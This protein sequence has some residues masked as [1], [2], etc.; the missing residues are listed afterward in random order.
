M[1]AGKTTLI[2]EFCHQLGSSDNFSSPTFTIVNEYFIPPQ[3]T[4]GKLPQVTCIYHLD[5]YRLKNFEE[6]LS[7]GIQEYLNSGNYCFI[8]WPELA[9]TLLPPDA[10]KIF[11]KPDGEVR[12]LFI[13]INHQ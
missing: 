8:E 10:V 7:I 12:N 13:F 4:T 3:P 9:E 6:V 2:K 5:L 1:G 11:I